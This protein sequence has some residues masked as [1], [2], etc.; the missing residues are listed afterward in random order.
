M[1]YFSLLLR[2][3]IQVWDFLCTKSSFFS[4]HCQ[5]LIRT[6]K[7]GTYHEKYNPEQLPVADGCVSATWLPA[8]DSY[9]EI[10]VEVHLANQNLATPSSWTGHPIKVSQAQSST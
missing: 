1:G 7:L 4:G 10:P 5:T 6:V 2:K 9:W 8:Q 3:T